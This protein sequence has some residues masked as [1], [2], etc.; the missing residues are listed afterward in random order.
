MKNLTIALFLSAFSILA[1]AQTAA[2]KTTLQDET[3]IKSLIESETKAYQDG[4]TEGVRSYW[5]FAPYAR[6]IASTPTNQT[7]YGNSGE[8][9]R[10]FYS[11]LKPSN[12]TSSNANYNVKVS[13]DAT[14]AWVTYDQTTRDK[15]GKTLYLSHEV[16]CL[17]QV[18]G[19]WKL[20]VMSAHYYMP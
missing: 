1:T 16:R 7:L 14:M 5:H 6:G 8:Q 9:I 20:V 3:A 18:N 10:Q 15:D 12:N 19:V 4:N 2:E 13:S 11:D 17:D